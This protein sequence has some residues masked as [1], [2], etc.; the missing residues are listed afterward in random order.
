MDYF[1]DPELCWNLLK[2][3]PKKNEKE[4]FTALQ[5]FEKAFLV[6]SRL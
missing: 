2:S 1:C 3:L 5:K 6:G 4:K